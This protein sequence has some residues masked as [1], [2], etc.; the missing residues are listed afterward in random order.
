MIGFAGLVGL[1]LAR[2]SKIKKQVFLSGF[3]GLAASIH[4]PQQDIK[5]VQ[6]RKERLYKRGLQGYIVGQDFWKENFLKPGNVRNSSEN[7]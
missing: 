3:M 1:L 5:F 6:V 7:K 4:Y 2:G